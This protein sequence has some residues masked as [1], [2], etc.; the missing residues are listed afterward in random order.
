VISPQDH[1]RTDD[2]DDHAPDIEAGYTGRTQKTE[3]D[4]THDGADNAKRDVEQHALA[5]LVDDLTPDKPSNKTEYD[6]TDDG[7]R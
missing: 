1:H 6:P 4:A 3:D 5:L 2:C 7:H